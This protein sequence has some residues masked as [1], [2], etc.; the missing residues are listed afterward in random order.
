MH[1]PESVQENDTHKILWDFEVQTDHPILA[2]S[3]NKVLIN[4]Q[5]TICHQVDFSVPVDHRGRMGNTWIFL[6][7]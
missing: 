5:K 2:K 6:E 4:K 7:S 3:P 1:K